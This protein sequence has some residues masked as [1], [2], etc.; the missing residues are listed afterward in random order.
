MHDVRLLAVLAGAA[1][2]PIWTD[3]DRHHTAT[4]RSVCAELD[5][6]SGE[7]VMAGPPPASLLRRM[8]TIQDT[9]RTL[10]NAGEGT[11]TSMARMAGDLL[12]AFTRRDH[13]YGD[14]LVHGAVAKDW[15][16]SARRRRPGSVDYRH[17][18]LDERH[19]MSLNAALLIGSLDLLPQG[20]Q[21]PPDFQ[22]ELDLLRRRLAPRGGAEL[23]ER[24]R[25][26]PA[27]AAVCRGGAPESAT[28]G[29]THTDP[30][31]L[32]F[33]G[34]RHL[35]RQ[36][37]LASTLLAGLEL[38]RDGAVRLELGSLDAAR[39]MPTPL[40]LRSP[41]ADVMSAPAAYPR[42]DRVP[43]GL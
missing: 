11:S 32:H 3:F 35:W 41:C 9:A 7:G 37:A 19:G 15:L 34:S 1:M 13:V 24:M 36:S 10:A 8:G 23:T 28:G 6:G 21:Q 14:R 29:R 30:A 42:L 43:V 27:S 31:V 17:L 16:G 22:A 18:G 25:R 12:W 20:V 5:A 26:L 4:A 33:K 40:A 2:H 38:S 39:A